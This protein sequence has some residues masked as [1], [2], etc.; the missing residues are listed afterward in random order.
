MKKEFDWNKFRTENIAVNCKTQ[1]EANEFF[2]EMKM[3]N[4]VSYTSKEKNNYYWNNNKKNTC[5]R[6]NS[7][8]FWYFGSREDFEDDGCVVLEFSDYFDVD[9]SDV[10]KPIPHYDEIKFNGDCFIVKEREECGNA[11]WMYLCDLFDLDYE[12][13]EQIVIDGIV[14]YFGL[15]KDEV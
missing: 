14:K 1:K 4:M 9:E 13:T 3:L 10:D 11:E 12:A 6:V 15:R 8:G 2:N 5:Y 7:N